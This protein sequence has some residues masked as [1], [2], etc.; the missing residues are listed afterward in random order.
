[1]L[2]KYKQFGGDLR[3]SQGLTLGLFEK[4]MELAH[5]TTDLARVSPP[6][7]KFIPETTTP[8]TKSSPLDP[9][10]HI[11]NNNFLDQIPTILVFSTGS[12]SLQN[13][14]IS[15]AFSLSLRLFLDLWWLNHL[16]ESL[17]IIDHSVHIFIVLFMK[18]VESFQPL[19]A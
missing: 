11:Y 16:F 10:N 9:T 4:L 12:L 3:S 18:T 15:I 6:V 5:S 7:T 2:Q 8:T 17:R 14:G 13:P 19:A 1:M